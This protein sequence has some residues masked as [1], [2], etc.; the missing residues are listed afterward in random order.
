[1]GGTVERECVLAGAAEERMDG[2]WGGRVESGF[3][4]EQRTPV[5]GTVGPENKC[6]GIIWGISTRLGRYNDGERQP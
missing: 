2:K 3:E 5:E 6:T 1:M 4:R